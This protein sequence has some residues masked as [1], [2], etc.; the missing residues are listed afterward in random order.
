MP[1][2]SGT[3]L[4]PYEII[5]PLGQGG[6][7]EVYKARDTRLDRNVAIKVSKDQFSERFEREARA[8]AALNHSH[9]CQL[10]DVGPNY[11]VMEYVE[12]API[13]PVDN[14][15][16]LLDLAAQ[17]AGGLVAAHAAGIVHRDLKPGN[18][19]VTRGGQ[20]KI[21]DFGLATMRPGSP[22]EAEARPTEAVTDPGVTVGTVAYMSPEQARGQA[23]DARTDLW[24]LGVVLYEM[25]TRVR[26]FDGPTAAVIFEAVLGK[27]PVPVR[28]RNPKVPPDLERIIGKLLEKDKTLRYQSAADVLADLK[29]AERDSSSGRVA[30]ATAAT[31]RRRT[32]LMYAVAVAGLIAGG[33]GSLLLDQARWTG[34]ITLRVYAA[35]Q[36]QRLRHGAQLVARRPYGDLHS[37]RGVL[38]RGR[39][40]SD[41]RQGAPGRRGRAAHDRSCAQI[42]PGL[43]A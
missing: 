8:V 2:Q 28:E 11:L 3:L 19:L 32:W 31:P 15:Q 4:G 43:H 22:E 21:L 42:G 29:R 16:Q 12:G 18:I 38:L 17:L 13:E 20:V 25:A 39:P 41:L 14:P 35:H 26:P 6:M 36:L 27:A 33:A 7:G 24:S 40:R 1:L 34:D 5:A 37:G 9:I 30:V 10:Y 23:V